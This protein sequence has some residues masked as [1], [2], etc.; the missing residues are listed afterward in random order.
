MML[1]V[2]RRQHFLYVLF[3]SLR[4]SQYGRKVLCLCSRVIQ[5]FLKKT[6]ATDL[7]FFLTFF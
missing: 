6:Q 5:A 2:F 1:P 3:I 7:Q 4:L